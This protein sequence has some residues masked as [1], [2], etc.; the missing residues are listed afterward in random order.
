M[1]RIQKGNANY[2]SVLTTNSE[3]DEGDTKIQIQNFFKA[4]LYTT[5]I[6]RAGT[7][8]SVDEGAG[9]TSTNV[10]AYL[11]EIIQKTES[12][13]LIADNL[14]TRMIRGYYTIR[15]NIIQDNP[16]IG[17]KKIIQ[18]CLLIVTGKVIGD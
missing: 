8:K 12:I 2:L 16:F 13:Q 4:P 18:L 1:D 17:G 15:T 10:V 3:V 9:T 11:P 14:P 6:P 7:L 5:M